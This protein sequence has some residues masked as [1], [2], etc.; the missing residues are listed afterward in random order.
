MPKIPTKQRIEGPEQSEGLKDQVKSAIAHLL[1]SDDFTLLTPKNSDFGDYALFMK[2]SLKPPT[3]RK[4]EVTR[5]VST[6]QPP[7]LRRIPTLRR[8]TG[9]RRGL[10]E[11]LLANNLFSKVEQKDNFINLYLNPAVLTE[12][13]EKIIEQKA[14]YGRIT[15][16]TP[17]RIHLEYGQPNTHKLPHVGHLFSYIYG[18]SLARLFEISGSSIF[19]CNYQGDVGLH[20]AKCMYAIQK[21]AFGDPERFRALVE[22]ESKGSV[23]LSDK[24]LFLQKCYQEVSKQYTENPVAKAEIDELNQ[25][26][27]KK[28][29]EVMELWQK[30]RQWSLD[31]YDLFEKHLGIN[32][33][34]HYFESDTVPIGKK[35]V[36]NGIG[37]IFEKSDAA[38]I[39]RGEKYGLHTRVFITKDGNPTYEAKDIGNQ[40][41]K[42]Q[43]WPY[44]NVII[45]T[46][47]EQN[48][49]FKVVIQA[50][51]QILPKLK[52]KVHHIGFGMID[53]KTGKMSSRSGNIISAFDLISLVKAEITH[54][55]EST[56]QAENKGDIADT[57]TQ[58]AIKYSFLKSEARKNIAFDLKEPI[59]TSGNSGPYLLY[60]Y[61][62]CQS[63]IA[64]SET[65]KQSQQ[66]STSL[67]KLQLEELSLLRS[68]FR[69]PEAITD[70]SSKYA[71]H[72]VCT[73]LY[74]LAQK[75]SS[76]YE[77]CPIL[78]AEEDQRNFRLNLTSATAQILKN[79]LYLLGIETLKR[80]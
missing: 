20:V 68:F 48:D 57:V 73:Y 58:A 63:V 52:G 71:P 22:E 53:L 54:I 67:N 36:E 9:E 41:L 5:N 42:Y 29:P 60:T 79:G 37:K 65:T 70:A 31:Y 56:T 77:K 26:I 80:I 39:F 33:D 25:K 18:E 27:Y 8:E 16:K 4:N 34:K 14:D 44:D 11:Q 45:T 76:F 15:G 49:Y 7:T 3:L 69:F 12:E 75:F 6:P 61:A 64:R 46:A 59:S 13:M 23:N 51:D 19:R 21:Y 2:P 32:Y 38:I 72:L 47:S 30:T 28:D 40:Y 43:D 74:D 50:I 62:R 1:K 17:K 55:M 66:I 35:I 78:K 10:I 24:I